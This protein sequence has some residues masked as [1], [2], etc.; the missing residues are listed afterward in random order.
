MSRIA[1]SIEDLDM[2]SDEQDDLA[3]V[4]L[5]RTHP[6][7]FDPEGRIVLPEELISHARIEGE[8]L[9]VGR[10]IRFQIWNPREYEESR[11]DVFERVRSRGATLSL[12]RV[13]G[14]EKQ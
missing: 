4:L 9:F 13:E 14:S 3:S 1:A 8:V 12:R 10:G 6:L 11:R 2:F 5:E 7:P